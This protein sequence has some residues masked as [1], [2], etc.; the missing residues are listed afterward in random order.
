MMHKLYPPNAIGKFMMMMMKA[1]VMERGLDSISRNFDYVQ[2]LQILLG[3]AAKANKIPKGTETV[4]IRIENSCV[5]F[6]LHIQMQSPMFVEC[7]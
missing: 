2:K 3:N 7:N 5:P 4:Q 1:V 6:S